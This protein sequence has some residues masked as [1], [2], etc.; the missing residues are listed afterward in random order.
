MYFSK[1]QL[2]EAFKISVPTV[3]KMVGSVPPVGRRNGGMVYHLKDVA[4]LIDTR[5]ENEPKEIEISPEINNDPEKMSAAE[6]RLHYQAE[7]LK[8][9]AQVPT[10]EC[11]LWSQVA[12]RLVREYRYPRQQRPVIT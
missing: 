12:A 10:Q 2:A 4:E 7:D 1:P 3:T 8:E 9:A 5:K 11:P 6:R